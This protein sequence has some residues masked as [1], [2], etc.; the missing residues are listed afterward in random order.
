MSNSQQTRVDEYEKLAK[1]LLALKSDGL[2]LAR[3]KG[4]VVLERKLTKSDSNKNAVS[5]IC[6]G[7]SFMVSDWSDEAEAAKLGLNPERSKR[8]PRIVIPKLTEAQ[9]A[10]HSNFLRTMIAKAKAESERLQTTKNQR[11]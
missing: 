6:E 7:I 5:V 1:S 8:F 2:V 11:R 9:I 4:Y 3:K 10:T